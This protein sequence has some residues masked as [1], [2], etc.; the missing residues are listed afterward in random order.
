M[1]IHMRINE[2][3]LKNEEMVIATIVDAT[4]STPGRSGFKML[5]FHDGRSEGTVGGGALEDVVR[6]RAGQALQ[7]GRNH[8]EELDLEKIGMKCGGQVKVF[9]EHMARE[10]HFYVFGGGHIG[11]AVA[12]ILDMLGHAVTIMDN[13]KEIA[14]ASLHPFARNVVHGDYGKTIGTMEIKSPCYALVVSHKHIH[15]EEILRQLLARD[16]HFSY[17]GMIGSR[18]KVK[19][20]L[21]RLL[22]EGVE[23]AKLDNI[24]SPVGINIGADTPAEIAISIVAEIIAVEKGRTVPHMKID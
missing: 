4:G 20:I 13:R 15:D 12:P 21:E 6:K 2:L 14:E 16:E 3:M 7:E 18:T 24:W 5:V 17:I 8:F 23:K 1:N 22:S 11:Q 9:Y 19:T 10:K